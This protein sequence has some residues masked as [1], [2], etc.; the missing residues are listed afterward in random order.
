MQ[1]NAFIF[2]VAFDFAFWSVPTVLCVS[3]VSLICLSVVQAVAID[4]VAHYTIGDL[5]NL[6]V[7]GVGLSFSAFDPPVKSIR[8]NGIPGFGGVPAVLTYSLIV[9][10]VKDGLF[11]ASQSYL[12]EGIAVANPPIQKDHCYERPL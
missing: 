4:M 10:R 6:A 5:H 11:I 2:R 9:L 1:G 7:H 3:T 8:I 12:P